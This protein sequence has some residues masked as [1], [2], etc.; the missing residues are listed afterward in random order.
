MT[1]LWELFDNKSFA[2]F[3]CVLCAFL[4]VFATDWRR[5]RRKVAP[6][7]SGIKVDDG[8]RQ[9]TESSSFTNL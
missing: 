4:L 5:E 6:I 9:L 7:K 2:A 1:W 3:F 8:M